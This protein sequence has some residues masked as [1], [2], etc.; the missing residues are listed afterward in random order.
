MQ[1]GY[2]KYQ[3]RIRASVTSKGSHIGVET[4]GDKNLTNRLLVEAGLPAP[5]G[6]AVRSAEEAVRVA[7]RLGYPVVTKPL[8]ANH[9]RGVS[10]NLMDA[11]HVRWGYEQAAKH[12]RGPVLVEHHLKGHDYRVLVVNGRVVA[13]ARRVPAHVVGD[14]QHTIAELI[15]IVNRDPRRGIGHEKV[16]T[17]ITVD[18]QVQRLLEQDG[19]TLDTVPPHGETVFLRATANMSTG[20]TA[21]DCT[22]QIHPDNR[23]IF[24]R[25]ALDLSRAGQPQRLGDDRRAYFDAFRGFGL[26]RFFQRDAAREEDVAGLVRAARRGVEGADV[27]QITAL[28][29]DLLAQFLAGDIF[30]GQA[31]RVV[32]RSGR[33]LQAPGIDGVAVLPDQNTWP[34][35]VTGTRITPSGRSA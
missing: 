12:G 21:I 1:L 27:P 10:L 22:D 6:E 30:E 31:A 14:G 13:A 5:Q 20:G 16:L 33:R 29:P 26:R 8:D 18:D 7:K 15:Q 17:R 23:D 3:Q 32:R 28:C 24:S 19:R 35:S 9:G 11:E 2:G 34:S 4:A 25:S